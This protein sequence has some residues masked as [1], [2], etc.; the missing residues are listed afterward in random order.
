MEFK[1]GIH[2]TVR[3]TSNNFPISNLIEYLL[4]NFFPVNCFVLFYHLDCLFRR[5][6]LQSFIY[7]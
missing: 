7:I 4:C 1:F 6:G 5:K 2:N 3:K